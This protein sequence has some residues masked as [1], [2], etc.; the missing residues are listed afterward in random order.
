[1]MRIIKQHIKKMVF[2]LILLC[3]HGKLLSEPISP[4]IVNGSAT[5]NQISTTT[6][7]NQSTN[8]LVINWESFNVKADE[9]VNFIQPNNS[10][11][12]LN[13]SIGLNGS[14][15]LGSL[16]ANGQ[17]FIIN[18][19][20]IVFGQDAQVNV[21]GLVASTLNISDENFTNRSFSFEG[22]AGSITNK[23]TLTSSTNGYIALLGSNVINEG[24]INSPLGS[25]VLASGDKITLDFAGDGLINL[26]VD[27]ATLDA[28]VENKG[29]IKADG[30]QVLM[31]AYAKDSLFKTILNN[32]GVIQ[33]Q[34]IENKNGVI[35][36]LGSMDQGEVKVSGKLDASA[37]ASGDGGFIETSGHKVSIDEDTI[38]TTHSVYGDSGNWLLD[39]VDYLIAASDGDATGAFVANSLASNNVSILASNDITINDAIN[40]SGSSGGTLTFQAGKSINI[41][42]DITTAN[43]DAYFY[44]NEEISSGV[45]DADRSSGAGSILMDTS[46]TINAGTGDITLEI[47][48]GTSKTYNTAGNTTLGALTGNNIKVKN[49]SPSGGNTVTYSGAVNAS[50]T[51]EQYNYYGA[52]S[53]TNINADFNV[54]GSTTTFNHGGDININADI[55]NTNAKGQITLTSGNNNLIDIAAGVDIDASAGDIVSF[56]TNRIN[57]DSTADIKGGTRVHFANYGNLKNILIG[58]ADDAANGSRLGLTL[59]KLARVDTPV[60]GMGIWS[61]GSSGPGYV[62]IDGA[63]NRSGTIYLVLSGSGVISTS[64]SGSITAS[65]LFLNAFDGQVNIDNSSGHVSTIAAIAPSGRFSYSQ[66][67]NFSVGSVSIGGKPETIL[68]GINSLFPG[69]GQVTLTSTEGDISI[70]NVIS[71]SSLTT[72]TPSG[73]VNLN[74]SVALITDGSAFVGTNGML[75]LG[76]GGSYRTVYS[77]GWSSKESVTIKPKTDT[78]IRSQNFYEGDDS[79]LLAFQQESQD[80]VIEVEQKLS[81]IE[82]NKA[83][84]E[85]KAQQAE[86]ELAA[87]KAEQAL[88]VA[89]IS[90]E[91]LQADQVVAEGGGNSPLEETNYEELAIKALQVEK[92]I[93]NIKAQQAEQELSAI[94]A[95]Q[96]L[97]S[98]KAEQELLANAKKDAYQGSQDLLTIEAQEQL[99]AVKAEQESLIIAAQQELLAIKALQTEQEVLVIK[100]EQ[101]IL[102][103]KAEQSL[104]LIKAQEAEQIV[105]A[106]TDKDVNSTT[107]PVSS[108]ELDIAQQEVLAIKA[109]QAVV[110]AKAQEKEQEVSTLK[111]MR[112]EQELMANQTEQKVIA[113]RESQPEL[114]VIEAEKEML[115]INDQTI[116]IPSEVYAVY[117]LP[118][119]VEN[120]GLN[121]GNGSLGGV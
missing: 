108:Q 30:G 74:G 28:Y 73:S 8:N 50:G 17:V 65:K 51:F 53:T 120:S 20:G 96:E 32:E 3:A 7:I 70:D 105:L 107:L 60:L 11:I 36:L 117:G 115:R 46:K 84:L 2:M 38:I 102:A 99:L 71:T 49:Y 37:P 110:A 6:S 98:I 103:I 83:L 119:V 90:Q 114:S 106:L 118:L 47:K 41:N 5:I 58:G 121:L 62:T 89:E 113:L 24:E 16:N 34:T 54:A 55:T 109:E 76:G 111:A 23:G 80:R 45:V 66:P 85:D 57:I 1:M 56:Q 18:P 101:D 94:K 64:A 79:I 69:R 88:N 52:S 27:Q 87:I 82:T 59:T 15:I 31:T 44:A 67:A 100:A 39:P 86:Q 112:E 4:Q 77:D 63:L 9:T 91:N 29:V 72:S 92:D 10:S 12:A 14:E 61:S 48:N 35:K 116:Q 40:T 81:T 33:A 22:E 75:D 42:A 104:L 93:L 19:N 25:N 21:G 78:V 13:R 43:G 97:L 26:S 95:E 68:A